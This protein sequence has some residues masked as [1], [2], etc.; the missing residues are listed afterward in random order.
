[1]LSRL[2]PHRLSLLARFAVVSAALISVLGVGLALVLRAVVVERAQS[3]AEDAVVVAVRLGLQPQLSPEDFTSGFDHR[4]FS[5]VEAAIEHAAEHA[6]EHRGGADLEGL[7]PVR[8]KIFNRTGTIVYSDHRPLVGQRFDSPGLRAALDGRV[9]SELTGDADDGADDDGRRQLLEVYVPVR[10]TGSATPD[11]VMEVYLAY[12]PVAQAVQD[13]VRRLST[14]LLVGLAAL[15]LGLYSLV[16]NASRRLVRAGNDLHEQAVRNE[17]QAT[18][19]ALTGLPNRTLLL[20]RLEE[21]LSAAEAT[22]E[23]VSVLLIDLDR[24]KE[25]ND[26][27]G[28]HYGDRVL[29]EVGPRLLRVLRDDD[30]LARLNGDEFGVVLPGADGETA[31]AVAARL[32]DALHHSFEVEDMTVDLEASIGLASSPNAGSTVED[33]LRSADIALHVAKE[34]RSGVMRFDPREHVQSPERLMLVGDLR[35]ALD[36]GEEL[37][38]HYQPKIDLAAG[39]MHGVEALLRWRHPSRGLVPPAEFIPV[40]E[41]TGLIIPLTTYV[42]DLALA[43]A[44]RWQSSGHDVPVAVNLSARC[45]LDP[46]LPA[47]VSDALRRHAVPA[48]LLRLELTESAVMGDAARALEILTTLHELGVHLSIDDFGTGYSSMAY[49]RRLPVDELKIDRAFVS[50]V[51]SGGNDD[52]LVRTAVE[53]GHNLG[54]T[55]VAEGVETEFHDAV[56]RKMG[57]DVA[58]G[59]H[60]ARPSTADGIS[61]WLAVEAPV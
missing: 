19:D 39:R 15:Y 34:V 50:E 9:V 28:H 38:L 20:H 17:H 59:Y 21:Q 56:L 27:L 46:S 4:R 53:L 48:R 40:A 37:F 13:D 60:Y 43:Q 25:V 51:G 2:H 16:A 22:G 3:Q 57:C 6:A 41:G 18:H 49:L 52:V 30:T 32:L 14:A 8:I 7:D 33:M 42:L 47:L 29:T 24:F 36:N 45:L 5:H 31:A 35:R 58:Q 12:G 23:P 61:R 55:V 10:Y 54:L 1:M 26:T 44:K 11:G